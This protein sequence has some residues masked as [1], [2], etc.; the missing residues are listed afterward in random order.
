MQYD[1]NSTAPTMCSTVLIIQQYNCVTNI[2]V[3]TKQIYSKY[4][5]EIKME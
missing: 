2:P 3:F 1:I 4:V 5:G